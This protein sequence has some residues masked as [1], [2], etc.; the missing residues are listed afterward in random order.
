VSEKTGLTAQDDGTELLFEGEY[1]E[2]P[3]DNVDANG[4]GG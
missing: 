4:K 3:A 2:W 1:N